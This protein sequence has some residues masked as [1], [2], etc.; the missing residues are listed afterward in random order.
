V[1]DAGERELSTWSNGK[2]QQTHG[3][4]AGV[5]VI[6]VSRGQPGPGPK[7]LKTDARYLICV[8]D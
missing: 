4:G 8:L 6:W 5:N 2:L 1:V 3:L 7:H